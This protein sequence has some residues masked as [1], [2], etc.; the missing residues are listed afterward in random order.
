[1]LSVGHKG[2]LLKSET[3][4]KNKNK[5]KKLPTRF[6]EYMYLVCIMLLCLFTASHLHGN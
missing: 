1:M 3:D 2:T 4:A 6:C 5:N